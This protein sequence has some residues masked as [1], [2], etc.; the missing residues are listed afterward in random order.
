MSVQLRRSLRTQKPTS[1]HPPQSSIPTSRKRNGSES[2]TTDD[3][4]D[5]SGNDSNARSVRQNQK[6]AKRAKRNSSSNLTALPDYLRANLDVVFCGYFSGCSAAKS[7]HYYSDPTN[8]FWRCLHRSG[9]TPTLFAASDDHSL[10]EALNLGLTNLVDEPTV[11]PVPGG[12]MKGFVPSLIRRLSK[13]RPR[14]VCVNSKG[15][16]DVIEGKIRQDL[17]LPKATVD[18]PTRWGLQPYKVVY[19]VSSPLV[20]GTDPPADVAGDPGIAE[21]SVRTEPI[22]ATPNRG[23][24]KAGPI[25]LHFPEV[26]NVKIEQSQVKIELTDVP[27]DL[28]A[29]LNSAVPAEAETTVPAF[30]ASAGGKE[31]RETLFFLVPGTSGAVGQYQLPDKVAYF[32][33]LKTKLEELKSGELD[34]GEMIVLPAGLYATDPEP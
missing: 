15:L 2:T 1:K 27:I 6:Q 33:E 5:D 28:S 10:P 16:W 18:G 23:V 12:I 20:N 29:N 8:H 9:F 21:H 24:D 30:V 26:F 19:D 11:K 14:I 3:G 7:G 25:D 17:G 4:H 13:F 31:P 22:D 32:T 34:R